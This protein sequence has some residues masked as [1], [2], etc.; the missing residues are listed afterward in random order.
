[1]KGVKLEHVIFYIS[2]SFQNLASIVHNWI[3]K[4][5]I[6]V[7]ALDQIYI[8][9]VYQYRFGIRM[10]SILAKCW[11]TS[12]MTKI[13]YSIVQANLYSSSVNYC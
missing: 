5:M 3:P 1:M 2:D 9:H 6:Y 8:I 4:L 11:K 12:K 13:T 7:I 10:C